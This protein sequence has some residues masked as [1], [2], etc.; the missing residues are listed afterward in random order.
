MANIVFEIAGVSSTTDIMTQLTC[1]RGR[2]VMVAIHPEPKSI[3]LFRFFWRELKL[4]GVRVY[5]PEDFD[6]AIAMAASGV[7]PLSSLISRIAPLEEI[8]QVF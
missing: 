3:D 2:I 8:Q 5:E 6:E 1:A 7:L 4:I